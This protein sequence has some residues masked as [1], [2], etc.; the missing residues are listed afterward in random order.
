M[1]YVLLFLAFMHCVPYV[2]ASLRARQLPSSSGCS[3][4]SYGSHVENTGGSSKCPTGS[5]LSSGK[6]CEVKCRSGY[7]NSN[8]GTNIYSCSADGKRTDATLVCSTTSCTLP[9]FGNEVVGTTQSCFAHATLATGAECTVE[10]A[11]G[12]SPN[13]GSTTYKCTN[14]LL[15][16]NP[17]LTCSPKTCTLP[18]FGTNTN[19]KEGSCTG[20]TLTGVSPGNTCTA[21]CDTPR[22]IKTGGTGLYSCHLGNLISSPLTC[23]PSPCTLPNSYGSNVDSDGCAAAHG[24]SLPSEDS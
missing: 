22:Y 15:T 21:V 10:C 16:K 12:Y 2:R 8:S 7:Y 20:T 9:S 1:K 13:S 23:T 3:M 4:P 24:S 18:P 14:G 11:S 19:T 17:S 6:G 5:A